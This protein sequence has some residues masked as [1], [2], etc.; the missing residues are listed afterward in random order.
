MV[1]QAALIADQQGLYVFIV[2][3]GKAAIRRVKTGET[4]A[5]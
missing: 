2:E 1:P 5:A 4:V 3:D